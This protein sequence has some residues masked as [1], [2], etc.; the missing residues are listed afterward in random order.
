MVAPRDI[1]GVHSLPNAGQSCG[2]FS[3]LSTCPLIHKGDSRVSMSSTSNAALDVVGT[4]LVLE[5]ETALG[6][7]T[8]P[9]PLAVADLE[10]LIDQPPRCLVALGPHSPGVLI[11][12]LRLAGLELP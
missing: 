2:F 11:L 8:D 3:P 1:C 9:A 10:N 7:E 6:Y 5:L 4:V 12:D